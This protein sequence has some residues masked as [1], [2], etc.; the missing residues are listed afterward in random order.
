MLVKDF[1]HFNQRHRWQFHR[2]VDLS[3]ETIVILHRLGII[4][5]NLDVRCVLL[6]D[7]GQDVIIA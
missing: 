1:Q 6:K 4:M 3:R 2:S 5:M 7:I